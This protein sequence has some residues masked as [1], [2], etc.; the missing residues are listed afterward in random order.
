ML[1]DAR[2]Y[3]LS[4]DLDLHRRSRSELNGEIRIGEIAANRESVRAAAQPPDHRAVSIHGLA[5]VDRDVVF[6]ADQQGAQPPRDARLSS[7]AE[8]GAPVEGGLVEAHTEA[9]ARL[10]R[11]VEEREIGAAVAIALLDSQ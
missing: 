8:R 11:V 2:G 6:G 1:C 7:C 5:S 9:E 4:E 3:P 10:Q